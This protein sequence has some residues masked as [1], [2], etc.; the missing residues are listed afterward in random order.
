MKKTIILTVILTVLLIT[1]CNSKTSSNEEKE[2]NTKKQIKEIKETYKDNNPIKLGMYLYTDSKTNRKL[3]SEYST[4]WYLNVDLLSLEVYY[5][6]DDEI[7][8]SNQKQVWDNYYQKY[9]NIDNYRIGYKIE[10][11]TTEG[12]F[13]KTILSPNDS[14]EIYDYIQIYLYDDINQTSSWYDHIDKD[15]YNES[16][17][18]TSI[19]LTGSTKT[20]KITSDITLTAF[21]YDSDDFDEN[22]EYRGISKYTT[23]IKRS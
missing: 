17:L 1:G 8:S 4:N 15:E 10:F 2:T 6:I 9:Q 19:K 13:S 23:T 20:D 12:E 22:N 11:T 18:I 16:T 3:T 5:T 14:D 21:T 7:P